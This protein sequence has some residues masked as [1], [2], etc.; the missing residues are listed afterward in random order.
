MHPA[1]RVKAF[2]VNTTSYGQKLKNKSP[3]NEAREKIQT[4]ITFQGKN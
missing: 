2:R 4:L 3:R 1:L